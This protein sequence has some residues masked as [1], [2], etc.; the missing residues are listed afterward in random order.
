MKPV[1]K[2]QKLQFIKQPLEAGSKSELILTVGI[3]AVWGKPDLMA[4]L[5]FVPFFFLFNFL[6]G[7]EI[8]TLE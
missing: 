8:I 5:L 2:S 3:A 4:I 6:G 1:R 7:R